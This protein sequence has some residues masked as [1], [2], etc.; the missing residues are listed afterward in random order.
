MSR[1]R[2]AAPRLAAI[3]CGVRLPRAGGAASAAREQRPPVEAGSG[4]G[5]AKML[6]AVRIL[7]SAAKVYGGDLRALVAHLLTDAPADLAV[8][9]LLR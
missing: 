8:Q 4:S 5:E 6:F 1:P 3:D 2:L 7:R 9:R